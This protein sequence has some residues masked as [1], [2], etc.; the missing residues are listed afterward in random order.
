[1]SGRGWPILARSLRKSGEFSTESA[2][3]NIPPRCSGEASRCMGAPPFAVFEGWDRPRLGQNGGVRVKRCGK[4]APPRQQ[5]SGQGKPHTEQD[6]IG[7]KRP[8]PGSRESCFGHV[9]ARRVKPSGRSLEP[10]SNARPRGM[11][12][13]PEQSGG[14]NSAYSSGCHYFRPVRPATSTS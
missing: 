3:E 12:V 10:R 5:C 4:S 13:P 11:A 1:M 14:Q 8:K 6:Q 9:P 7:R 2:T